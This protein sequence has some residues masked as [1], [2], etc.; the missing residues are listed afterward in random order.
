MKYLEVWDLP[1]SDHLHTVF[2][3]LE[4]KQIGA[5]YQSPLIKPTQ[6]KATPFDSVASLKNKKRE[7]FFFIVHV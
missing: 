6:I 7:N 4:E 2:L 5:Y 1:L 3:T